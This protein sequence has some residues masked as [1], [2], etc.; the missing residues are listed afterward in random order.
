[1]LQ[2]WHNI[3]NNYT[4][5]TKT[6]IIV[7]TYI[8]NEIKISLI[9]IVGYIDIVKLKLFLLLCVLMMRY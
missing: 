4:I 7:I 3:Y 1:M 6:F 9:I 8:D 5:L 2:L